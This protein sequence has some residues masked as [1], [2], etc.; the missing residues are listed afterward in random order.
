MLRD[1]VLIGRATLAE[2]KMM[3]TYCV[4]DERFSDGLWAALLE[5]GRIVAI[6]KRL[7]VLHRLFFT[8]AL[9]LMIV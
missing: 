7:R 6:L 4:R 9:A 8:T 2:I 3:L 5:S 1:G